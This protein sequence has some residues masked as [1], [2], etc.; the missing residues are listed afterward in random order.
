MA[1]TAGNEQA[2]KLY[3]KVAQ[4]RGFIVYEYHR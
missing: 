1:V 4:F 2:R 3:D